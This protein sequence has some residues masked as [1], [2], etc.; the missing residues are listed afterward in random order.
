[1]VKAKKQ[2][3]VLADGTIDLETWLDHLSNKGHLS[4]LQLIRNAYLLSQVAGSEKTTETGESCLQQGLAMAEILADLDLDQTTLAAAIIYDSVQY[5]ELSLD[6][7]REQLG[8]NVA[9]LIEGVMRM[10]TISLMRRSHA[11]PR[12]TGSHFQAENLRKMLIAMVDNV[13]VVL[14]KLAERLRVLRT[15][16]HLDDEQLRHEI[17]QEAL[18]IYVPLANRLSIGQIKWELEDLTFRYL[19]SDTY[20]EIASSLK[21]RRVDRDQYVENIV[22]E[23]ETALGNAGIKKPKIY[24]RSKHIYSIYRKMQRKN[25]D[26][27]KIYD[28][29]AV[30]VLVD[31]IEECYTALSVIHDRW[32]PIPEEFDDYIAHPKPNGYRSL[33]TAAT[34]KDGKTFEVQIRTQQ[35]HE[36]AELGVA[37]HWAYKTGEA[38]PK[39]S[40]HEQKMEWLR[41]VLDWQKEITE[42][43]KDIKKTKTTKA[44]TTTTI[45]DRIYV[46]TPAGDIIDLP[47]GATPLD[48]AYHIHS[49]VG[50]RCRG[51]KINDK[52]VP[53]TH[54]LKTSDQVSILTAKQGKPS[55]DWLNP[56]LGYLKTSR[57]RAKV[58]QWF[59]S[60]DYD[61]DCQ[62]GQTILEQEFRK[63]NLPVAQLDEVA[64]KLNYKSGDGM[65]AALG[66]GELKIG[67]VIHVL[68]VSQQSPGLDQQSAEPTTPQ[69]AP[70]QKPEIPK[71]RGDFN[72]QGVDN[73]LSRPARCCKPIPGDPIIGYITQGK[74]ISIHRKDCRNILSVDSTKHDRLVEV[75]W[76]TEQ[77]PTYLVDLEIHAYERQGLVRDISTIV[78]A[79]KINIAGIN[80]RHD[81]NKQY[82]YLTLTVEIHEMDSLDKVLTKLQQMTDVV[83]VERLR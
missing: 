67:H 10:N 75:N 23:L 79:E 30:R 78:T 41:Q 27:N 51:A 53:L 2:T 14:I 72:I 4:D 45:E 32:E 60:Q 24:G 29:T 61:K 55:R 77:A 48:F 57:A 38:K 11:A 50:H 28:V 3:H 17:A 35:M 63:H 46:F 76:G 81:K 7:V 70:S 36:E 65:M 52:I 47:Q 26:I 16:A 1:M 68:G 64:A 82:A 34:S 33:H 6:D 18:E 69:V 37:A 54:L 8:E 59:K 56:E 31:T 22:A 13:Q 25:V 12:R 74:G 80:L 44:A 58:H 62:E 66:R 9:K 5:A 73:L 71:A 39:Q 40:A 49:D 20:K 15:A 19:H 43:P 83:K 21:T 42:Q